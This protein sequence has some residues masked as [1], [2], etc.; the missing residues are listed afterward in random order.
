MN[1]K[2]ILH[3]VN[4][5]GFMVKVNNEINLAEKS[6]FKIVC[7]RF[8]I[9]NSDLKLILMESFSL[10]ESLGNIHSKKAKRI[11]I[12]LIA[13]IASVDGYIC[14]TEEK[15]IFKI[16]DSLGE[17]YKDYVYFQEDGKLDLQLV[18]SS[19]LEILSDLPAT[20]PI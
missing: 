5:L 13:L 2:E 19:E 6:I 8:K 12:N 7:Q 11:L 15:S 16:M 18:V 20:S 1:K 17:S 14:D 10:K 3:I 9:K 4:I